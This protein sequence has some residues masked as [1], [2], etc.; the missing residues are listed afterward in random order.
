MR[1]F[2]L[3]FQEIQFLNGRLVDSFFLYI[4]G[5]YLVPQKANFGTKSD[6]MIKVLHFSGATMAGRV[7]CE[8]PFDSFLVGE[9]LALINQP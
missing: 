1:V 5:S 6:Y 9:D 8:S 2:L 7:G 3:R 4:L